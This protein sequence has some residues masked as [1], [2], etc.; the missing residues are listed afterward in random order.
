MV[1][2]IDKGYI[3]YETARNF[4]LELFN[5]SLLHKKNGNLPSSFFILCEH[6]PVYT[7]GKSGSEANILLNEEMLGAP[8][9][10]IERGGDVTFHGPGQIVGYPILDLEQMNMGLKQYIEA[11]EEVIIQTIAQYGLNGKRITSASGVWIDAGTAKE[12]KICAIGV[13]ASRYITMHGFAFNVNTDLSWFQKINPCGFTDKGVTSLSHE[14]GVQ[15]DFPKVKQQVIDKFVELF[16][17]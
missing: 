12:R 15:Q 17:I 1:E 8:V 6:P 14:L 5:Q 10:K 9:F 13:R 2:I 4:Q 16:S 11:L 7:I 3:D